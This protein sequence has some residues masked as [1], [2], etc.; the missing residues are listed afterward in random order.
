MHLISVLLYSKKLLW[1]KM[2]LYIWSKFQPSARHIT[3]H[4][5]IGMVM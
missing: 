2:S 3:A 5:A 1:D 4:V